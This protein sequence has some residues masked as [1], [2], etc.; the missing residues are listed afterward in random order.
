MSIQQTFKCQLTW[1][2]DSTVISTGQSE[3]SSYKALLQHRNT[4]ATASYYPVL[5]FCLTINPLCLRIRSAGAEMAGVKRCPQTSGAL[6]FVQFSSM[7][8]NHGDAEC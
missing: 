2:C 8:L 3:T 5:P 7:D 6:D 1:S 4:N